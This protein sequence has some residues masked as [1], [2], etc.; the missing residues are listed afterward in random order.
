M[1][2]FFLLFIGVNRN[3][4]VFLPIPGKMVITVMEV[5]CHPNIPKWLVQWLPPDSGHLLLRVVARNGLNEEQSRFYLPPNTRNNK[6]INTT[7]V[8]SNL[9]WIESL[10]KK[11]LSFTS[12]FLLSNLMVTVRFSFLNIGI[13]SFQNAQAVALGPSP[14]PEKEILKERRNESALNLW[15]FHSRCSTVAHFC[16]TAANCLTCCKQESCQ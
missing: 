10:P 6:K 12:S 9:I 2:S 14:V 8:R 11:L 5:C 15:Y 16:G 3:I 4:F 7:D 13:N 1:K